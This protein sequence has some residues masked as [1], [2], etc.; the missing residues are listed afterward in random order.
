MVKLF[1][2]NLIELKKIDRTIQKPGLGAPNQQK[3]AKKSAPIRTGGGRK[4]KK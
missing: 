4:K 3:K 2:L 1:N